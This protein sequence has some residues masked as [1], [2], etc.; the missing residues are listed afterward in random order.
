[1][2]EHYGSARYMK[3]QFLFKVSRMGLMETSMAKLVDLIAFYWYN[4]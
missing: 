1:M 3:T 4:L 2:F